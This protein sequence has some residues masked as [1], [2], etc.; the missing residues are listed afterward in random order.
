M[1]QHLSFRVPWHDNGWNGTVCNK[2]AENYSCMRLKGINQEKNDELECDNAGCEFYNLSCVNEMP[3][4]REGGCFMSETPVSVTVSHPYQAFSEYH[5]HL[6]PTTEI[7]PAF[8]YPARPFRWTMKSR[9]IGYKKYKTIDDMALEYGFTYHAEYEPQIDNKTWVQDGRNQKAVFDAFFNEVLEDES[10]C[11]FYAKQVPFVED[12]RRVVI[13]IGHVKKVQ[14]VQFYNMQDNTKMSSCLWENMVSHSIREDMLD[15]FLIPYKELMEYAS[16]HELFDIT[17]A[18]VFATDDY[19][20]EFSYATEHLSHDAVIDVIL[21][22]LKVLDVIKGC[23]IPGN[24]DSCINW[25]NE[26]LI[27]VWEDRGAFPGLGAMLT[28]FGIPSGGVIARELK[29]NN[30][31]TADIWDLVNE[32]I[33]NPESVLSDICAKQITGTIQKTWNGLSERRK[34]VFK[35]L[36]RV[37]LS[38][39]QARAVYQIE[40]REENKIAFTDEELINNPYLLYEKT[41][42]K[43]DGL[44]VSIKKVDLAFYPA[45]I[46]KE[47]Y[48]MDDAS[49]MDSEI[50]E[51]RV[52]A[53]AV[54]VLETASEE[55]NTVVPIVNLVLR[56]NNLNIEPKCLVTGDMFS[57]MNEFFRPEIE[58]KQDGFGKDYYKLIRYKKIDFLIANQVKKRVN[59]PNRHNLDVDWRAR[60]DAECDKFKSNPDQARENAAREE[61]A[62]ALKT[63]SDARLS[64]LIGGAGT[65]KTTVLEILCK[66]ESIQ[67]GGIL[68]L[69]PTGKA[70]VRMSLGLRGKVNFKAKTIAQF[71]LQSG[72]FDWNTMRY[73]ILTPTERQM[74]RSVSVPKTVIVDESSM[75]T[76]DMF[77][78]LFDAISD[79]ERII[80]IGDYNQLPPIGAGRPFV[81]MVRYIKNIDKIGV[82]PVVGNNFAKLTVTNRQL[83][84]VITKK[85]RSDVRLSKWY[86]DDDEERDDNIFYEI[87]SGAL[88]GNIIF[89]QWKDKEDLEQKLLESIKEVT[90]MDSID[91]LEGFNRSLGGVLQKSGQY[92]GITFFNKTRGLEHLGA[93][94][95]AEDWQILSPVRN[96]SHGVL[97]INHIIHEKYRGDQIAFAEDSSSPIPKKM[98]SDGIVF[99]DKVINVIN[100]SR[101]GYPKYN[102]DNYVANGEIGM[103]CGSGGK[104]LYLQVEYSSQIGFTYSYTERGD[105]GD[106]G[107][108]PL[109]LAYSLTV[110]K[111]QGSQFNV[112]IL[113]L[114]DKCFLMSKEMLYTAI[115]RQ[116]DKLI[117][118]YDE[119]AYN[120]KKYSSMECSDIA[121]RCTDL[122]EAPK[123]VEFKNKYY[124]EK[125]IHKTKNGIMVRSKS[126][127][128]LAN[129]FCDSGRDD[130]LYEEPLYIAG[131]YKLPDFTFKDVASGNCIIWEHLGMLGR[132]EY[133]KS[134]EE[135]KK[136]YEEN[137]ISEEN[138]NLIISVDGPDGS[139][140][141][142]VIQEKI[143]AFLI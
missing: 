87:Q 80:F 1:A 64:V 141:C 56:I 110:H 119:E 98:G 27:L 137:G 105:F 124:E 102:C 6:L 12:A 43:V 111:S 84:N 68:L 67:N 81:D 36:S 2:P 85:V 61:K 16:E 26:Q 129:M 8:S 10:L 107:A 118:L 142:Q 93:A 127:V 140:D 22:C 112:V 3:C 55:G 106:E 45:D 138:G 89:K 62:I 78:A 73:K 34:K 125:L 71:L 48:P 109:E 92:E 51:R 126:E 32:A 25:L 75:I 79:A 121:Q 122:F 108:N 63:L 116:K 65:G 90:E 69:A 15:G 130:F 57:G 66:E 94:S 5:N 35:L 131:T 59:S 23:K 70:R 40:F 21:Q 41:R 88:D 19:F 58:V 136:F 113:V 14:P 134:W 17:K 4:I 42:E 128:I 120:L 103:A 7:L 20:E 28:A 133:R 135:K 9:N 95:K 18:V 38:V 100:Q 47:K 53:L 52:R 132:E 11:V 117:I 49:R 74:V 101:D 33:N 104:K 86:T 96:G 44:Q 139:I 115:T 82:F 99:G 39:L 50:D 24:W 77:G 37:N 114:S 29:K 13:G 30:S 123:F 72:R 97:H 60:V 76:E 83:P 31:E 54:S 91:D 46:I 143:N